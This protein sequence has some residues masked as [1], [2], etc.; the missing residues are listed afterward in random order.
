[1]EIWV[2]SLS[3]PQRSLDVLIL[4][5]EVLAL[6]V[7]LLCGICVVFFV[8]WFF[9]PLSKRIFS[10]LVQPCNF[11]YKAGQKP[12]LRSRMSGK[13]ESISPLEIGHT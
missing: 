3:T 6:V 1:M 4:D 10:S 7:H 12:I 5:H 2:F 8:V 9:Y 13:P 11:I